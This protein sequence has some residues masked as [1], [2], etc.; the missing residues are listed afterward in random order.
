[1]TPLFL[2][3]AVSGY[4]LQE[5]V[6]PVQK[7]INLLNGMAS[8]GR[9]EM[10]LEATHHSE[11][12]KWC[13]QTDFEK[14]VAIRDGKAD[15]ERLSAAIEKADAD[16]STLGDEINALNQQINTW[17]AEKK[18]ATEIRTKSHADYE[19]VHTE[20][21]DNLDAMSAALSTLAAKSSG[22]IG[23]SFVQELNNHMSTKGRT[24]LAA[25]LQED[26]EV[27][28]PT[29]PAGNAFEFSSSSIVD[30]VNQ[31]KEKMEDERSA[32]E[33]EEANAHHAFQMVEQQLTMDIESAN[34]ERDNKVRVKTSRHEDS[35]ADRGDLEETT[36]SKEADEKYLA[37]LVAQCQTK[38]SEFADRQQ[39]RKDELTA[40]AKAT[41]IISG[42]S[43][44]GA[45]DTHLPALVQK[46]SFGL[47]RSKAT[48]MQK[49]VAA[50]LQD[51]AT[52]SASRV[53]A[54]VAT[55]IADGPFDKVKSMIEAM[56]TKLTEE[57][58]DEADHKGWCDGE[59]ASNKQMREAKTE[60]S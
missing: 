48:P 36:I 11:Y 19:V 21:N 51:R 9:A 54:L 53:L 16:A 37:G 27:Q 14:K 17:S 57:A 55:K 60:E 6:T 22:S 58:A 38:S 2:L 47:L 31:L 29:A 42:G 12:I 23:N 15:M 52:Q 56:I 1:M 45:A 26:R 44:S 35:A 25:F 18:Q 50:Y 34:E 30:T 20:Y 32:V 3:I 13:E 40:L 46:V 5:G 33:K 24:A 8:K 41:E 49:R 28:M 4:T 43:V 10:E 59:M 7:V 39:L